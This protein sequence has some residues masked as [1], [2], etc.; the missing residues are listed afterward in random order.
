MDCAFSK[1]KPICVGGAV[2][3][4]ALR[5]RPAR[6]RVKQSQLAEF[7]V[8]PWGHQVKRLTASLQTR[9]V[10]RNKAKFGEDGEFGVWAD[11]THT[12]GSVRRDGVGLRKTLAGKLR[13]GLIVNYRSM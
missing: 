4:T 5:Q 13:N 10:V 9:P 12:A 11:G 3:D 2:V 8:C 6:H 7:A 1:T